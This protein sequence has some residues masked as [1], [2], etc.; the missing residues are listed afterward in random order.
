MDD[1]PVQDRKVF[2]RLL[3]EQLK[4][5]REAQE[6]AQEGG[7][8]KDTLLRTPIEGEAS[9][10]R[11]DLEK[12]SPRYAA[13]FVKGQQLRAEAEARKAAAAAPPPGGRK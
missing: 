6:E 8:K 4:R 3:V 9:M 1:M 2:F 10:G 7:Q 13:R 12:Q 5:E 11:T